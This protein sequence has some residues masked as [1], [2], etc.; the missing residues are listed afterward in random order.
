MASYALMVA[1][2][3]LAFAWQA[4]TSANGYSR[5]VWQT[6]HGL[7]QDTI[8]ALVQSNDGY[9]WIGTSGG[10]TRFDGFQFSVFNREN[11][12]ALRE[13]SVYSL[14]CTRDGTLWI[15]TEGGGLV[16]YRA[17]VFQRFGA[18]EGL[19]NGF[20]RAIHEDG[21]GR[22]WVGTDLGLFRFDGDRL[23]RVDDQADVPEMYVH[24]LYVD[25][26]GRLWVGGDGLLILSDEGAAAY[27]SSRGLADNSVRAIAESGDGTIWVATIGG[28][29]RVPGG[30]PA[31]VFQS[32]TIIAHNSTFL[33]QTKEGDLWAGTYGLGLFRYRGGEPSVYRA[34]R[35]LPDNHI[36]ALLEDREGNFWVGTQNGL[37]RLSRSVVSTIAAGQAGAPESI[38]TVYEDRDGSIWMTTLGGDL[39]R[40][41]E[42]RPVP[43]R[44]PGPA[45][46]LHVRTIFRDSTGALW[47]GATEGV[48]RITPHGVARYTMRHGLINDFV[49][50]FCESR[51][52]SIWIGTDGGLS[53]LK[54]GAF[55]NF[56]RPE[57][58]AYGSIRAL[59]EDARGDLWVAT[60]GGVSRFRDGVMAQDP[61][62]AALA[63]VKVW[64]IHEDPDGGLWFGTRGAGLFLLQADQ[65]A[66]FTT[67]HGLASNNVHQILEDRRGNLWMSGPSGVFSVG[68]EDLK[69]ILTDPSHR[70]A[71]SPYGMSEGMETNQMNGGVQPAGTITAAGEVWFPS[72]RGA[73][74]VVPDQYGRTDVPPVLIEQV[75]A[76]GQEA[77][78]KDAI[79]V[80]PGEGRLEIH[81]TAIRL[82]SSERIRFR[83]MLEGFEQEWTEA[84]GR[85]AAY[86]TNLPSGTYRFRVAAYEVDDP[87]Y[88]S[89]AAI[90]VRLR[91]RFYETV[92]FIALCA[93]IL[94]AAGL[95][96]YRLRVRQIHARFA[97]VLA[98]RNRLAREMH[99]TLIQG[100]VGISTLLDAAASL[101]RSSPEMTR[102]L[103]ERA[104]TQA[105]DSVDEARRAVWNLRH[106]S[107][108]GD[109]LASA[110]ERLAQQVTLASGVHIDC[111]VVGKAAPLDAQ[112]EH[113]LVMIA[114]EAVL[115]AVHHGRPQTVLLSASFDTA[116]L[117]VR[118]SDDGCGFE[119]IVAESEPGQHYGLVGMSERAKQMGGIFTLNSAPG[120]GTEIS[121]TVPIRP[122]GRI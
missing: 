82:R 101:Q 86:Y 83:Y 117:Q 10:L 65:L 73:V 68:R 55:Q 13:E 46:G 88:F 95:A 64:T 58:L 39:Y 121:V 42:G 37:L 60:D 115:N 109:G 36:L 119:F 77:P 93:A 15:G 70:P 91:P 57:G 49:R 31:A 44:L 11:T 3:A 99:D 75:V 122:R 34:P 8:N 103:L 79:E 116:R 41:H 120:K 28:L 20:V 67:K 66:A 94:G 53:R 59:H 26:R 2:I 107:A 32:E 51:D 105:R 14:Y 12:P 84:A 30:D 45:N 9:L 100:C 56:H 85:R 27:R 97:A 62:L 4:E 22:L 106:E 29:H 76:D 23:A 118:V 63:G 89:E 17:G 25:R 110:L 72:T 98:E 92:W 80:G 38:N 18:S 33:Y 90:G 69:R 113:D 6:Q 81:Y 50:A 71:I 35:L 114:K 54:Q 112:V 104:R 21:R 52:G 40:L 74:R 102:E 61:R 7:P 5:R 87:R 19:T 108:R 78:L 16:R 43:A 48:A 1:V 111:E 47:V 96:A 24:A